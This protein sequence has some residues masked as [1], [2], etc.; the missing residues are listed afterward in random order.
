M[1][2]GVKDMNSNPLDISIAG[3]DKNLQSTLEQ[4]TEDFT[5]VLKG[6]IPKYA[7]QTD[8]DSSDGGTTF[9]KGKGYD[10]TIQKSIATIGTEDGFFYGP[11][12][13]FNSAV[14]RGNS[15]TISQVSFYRKNDLL[16][17]LKKTHTPYGK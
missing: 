2:T 11:V 9:Y 13:V 12:L 5:L 6:A 14:V 3:K 10:L 16:V 1:D 15:S 17:L 4:A 8:E 7:K